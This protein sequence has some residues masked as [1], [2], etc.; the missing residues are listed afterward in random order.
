MKFRHQV[1]DKN[2]E[3]PEENRRNYLQAYD[4]ETR[5]TLLKSILGPIPASLL[6][7]AQAVRSTIAY[8][9]R[10]GIFVYKLRLN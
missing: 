8:Y 1:F 5:Q 7:P 6:P 4:N 3:M 2:R 10:Q 9:R